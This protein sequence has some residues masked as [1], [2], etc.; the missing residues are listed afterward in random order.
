MTAVEKFLRLSKSAV[1]TAT[2]ASA[3]T[4]RIAGDVIF[5]GLT[6]AGSGPRQA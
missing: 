2:A 1:T 6:E 5:D 3:S 4:A